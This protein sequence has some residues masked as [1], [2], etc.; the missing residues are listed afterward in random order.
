[1]RGGI[2]H[3]HDKKKQKVRTKKKEKRQEACKEE[4][5]VTELSEQGGVKKIESAFLRA[6]EIARV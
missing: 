1:V 4:C 6:E 2:I 3:E 5:L